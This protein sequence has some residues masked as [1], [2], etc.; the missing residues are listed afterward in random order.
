MLLD[1]GV[2]VHTSHAF[3]LLPRLQSLMFRLRARS[4]EN[5][6]ISSG[7]FLNHADKLPAHSPV[8]A[9]A[10]TPCPAFVSA[11]HSTAFLS[12]THVHG[13]LRATRTPVTRRYLIHDIWDMPTTTHP[14]GFLAR[15]AGSFHAHDGRRTCWDVKAVSAFRRFVEGSVV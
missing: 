12:S 5:P 11:K 10:G 2:A 9:L 1:L 14:G 3:D 15:A 6:S 8:P 13:P 7:F 4:S